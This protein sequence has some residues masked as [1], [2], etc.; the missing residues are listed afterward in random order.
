[1]VS[2][3]HGIS[4]PLRRLGY[5]FTNGCFRKSRS[6]VFM[7]TILV[8]SILIMKATII[9]YANKYVL[10]FIFKLLCSYMT[11]TFF[12]KKL[13]FKVVIN[14]E[15][16]IYYWPFARVGTSQSH[17]RHQHHNRHQPQQKERVVVETQA[18]AKKKEMQTLRF[19]NEKHKQSVAP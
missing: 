19:K 18:K 10:I 1:M 12:L 3:A 7:L 14:V 13:P 15:W 8:Q 5:P 2:M 6:S 16:G 11:T 9:G 4:E 17:W